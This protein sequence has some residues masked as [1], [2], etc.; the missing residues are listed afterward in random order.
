MK[1]KFQKKFYF[2]FT[3]NSVPLATY[4]D[5]FA[6][7]YFLCNSKRKNLLM[8]I[9]KEKLTYDKQYQEVNNEH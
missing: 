5:D 1:K 9:S 6:P 4:V 2:I 8:N 7:L 3:L